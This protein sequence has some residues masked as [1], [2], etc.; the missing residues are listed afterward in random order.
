MLIF[1]NEGNSTKGMMSLLPGENGDIL[2]FNALTS[3]YN[4]LEHSVSVHF[5]RLPERELLRQEEPSIPP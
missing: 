1:T 5:L 2:R 3:I 4:L